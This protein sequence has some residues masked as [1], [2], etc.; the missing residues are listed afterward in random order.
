MAGSAGRGLDA[1]F[2]ALDYGVALC[3]AGDAGLGLCGGGG[4]VFFRA[5]ELFRREGYVALGRL[6]GELCKRAFWVLYTIQMWVGMIPCACWW[7]EFGVPIG[8]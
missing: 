1:R 7:D 2:C 6:E 4:P 5:R 3:W 8:V